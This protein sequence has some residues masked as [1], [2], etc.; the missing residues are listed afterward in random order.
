MQTYWLCFTLLSDAT[1]GQGEGVAGL[2]DQD[3]THDRD[4]FPYLRGRT[5]KGLLNEECANLLYAL[6]CQ[7]RPLETW[8]AAAQRLF[9]GSGSVLQDTALLHVGRASLPEDLREAVR[10]TATLSPDEVLESLTDIRQQTAVNAA[11]GA[12]EAHTLRAMRVILRQTPFQAR[13]TFADA[14]ESA[15]LA[16]LAACA[17]ALRRAGTGRNRGR[18]WLQATLH[19]DNAGCPGDDITAHHLAVFARGEAQP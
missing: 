17:L 12:P 9:G 6:E 13:L 8:R 1:F 15:D 11:T 3:V 19:A 5:L 18:G 4:G 2:V 14:P 7:K 10:A 16:L